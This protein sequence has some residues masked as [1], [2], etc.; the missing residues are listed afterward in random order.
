MRCVLRGLFGTLLSINVSSEPDETEEATTTD[1][2]VVR[3]LKQA[4]RKPKSQR[5]RGNEWTEAWECIKAAKI[6]DC[7]DYWCCEEP[8][9]VVAKAEE[10]VKHCMKLLVNIGEGCCSY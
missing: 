10:V 1:K 2:R 6:K 5:V 8:K 3:K 4:R 9:C 7:S